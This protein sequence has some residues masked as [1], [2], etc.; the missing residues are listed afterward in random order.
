LVH[1]IP[2]RLPHVLSL[3]LL[4]ACGNASGGTPDAS[5]GGCVGGNA[6]TGVIFDGTAGLTTSLGDTHVDSCG[7]VLGGCPGG[8]GSCTSLTFGGNNGT[9]GLIVGATMPPQSGA[10]DCMTTEDVVVSLN[11]TDLNDQSLFAGYAGRTGTQVVGS[12]TISNET[13]D[14]SHWAGQITATVVDHLHG[15]ATLTLSGHMGPR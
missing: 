5:S 14:G 13:L 4:G 11:Q 15:T 8:S 7:L 10:F 6:T 2:S 9:F 1:V 3:F 12:C